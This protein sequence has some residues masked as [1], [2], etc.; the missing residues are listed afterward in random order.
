[1]QQPLVTVVLPIYNVEKYLD[2]CVESVVGQTYGNLEILMI[3]DGSP[4]R[5]PEMCDAWAK[6]DSRIRVIH[7]QNAGLG[8]AR[9]TG[10]ENASGQYI[11][12]FDSD[13]YVL[14]QTVEL[15]LSRML[16]EDAQI[17]V[18]GLQSFDSSGNTVAS[19]PPKVGAVTYRGS[20]VQEDFLPEY[21]APHA[22]CEKE[23]KFYMSSCVMLYSVELI[24]ES[25]WRFVSERTIVSED[26]YSLLSL[27]QYVQ[28][29]TVIPEAFYCYR[30]ND[31]SLSRSYVPG[32]Y[33]RIRHF[34][35]ETIKLCEQIGYADEICQR[36]AVP[37]LDF[38]VAALKQEAGS[39]RTLGERMKTVRQIIRD[40]ILQLVLRQNKGNETNRLKRLLFFSMRQKMVML[41]FVLL[42][43]KAR[44]Q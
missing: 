26:V 7:K 40:D 23:R 6:K 33:E 41:C 18:F 29:V 5:C 20:A 28:S 19:Y 2:Q 22:R 17:A 13:D 34:Y 12:F 16:D 3:D 9:N 44:R 43:G 32:K 21:V 1:M 25:G 14:P 10:I 27:F 36:L 39:S 4:D 37:Y 24:R 15:S 42:W 30:Q 38:T 11:C 8:E 31:T 35:Q